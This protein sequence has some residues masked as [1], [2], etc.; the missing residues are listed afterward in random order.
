MGR[1][2]LLFCGQRD[3]SKYHPKV[4]EY[5]TAGVGNFVEFLQFRVGGRDK[6]LEQHL[7][8]CSKNAIYISKTSQND[9]ISCCGQFIT[10]LVVIKIK[11]NQFFQY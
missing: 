1:L 8:N 7:R 3:D 4:G 11:E 6:V 5:S 2:G 10:E 9:L